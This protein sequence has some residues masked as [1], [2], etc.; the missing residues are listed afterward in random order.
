[1]HSAVQTYASAPDSVNAVLDEFDDF[2]AFEQD[3][4]HETHTDS[5]LAR[6]ILQN[7]AAGVEASRRGFD[8]L[9]IEQLHEA[10]APVSGRY[11]SRISWMAA[12]SAVSPGSIA[13]PNGR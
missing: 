9:A 11:S 10:R 3:L 4:L 6:S 5:H 8:N 1:M 13:P 12:S 2:I 7:L